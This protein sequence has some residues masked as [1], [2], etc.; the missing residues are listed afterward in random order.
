[1]SQ[2]N[3]KITRDAV[4]EITGGRNTDVMR[5]LNEWRAEQAKQEKSAIVV[6]T[7]TKIAQQSEESVAT[8]E[9]SAS[10]ASPSAP[11][12]YTTAPQ[13]DL[14]L[15]GR[16]SAERAAAMLL[17][18]N[19]LTDF[20]LENPDKLPEDLR[21]QV[22]A[23]Q[24]KFNQKSKQRQEAYDPETFTRMAIAQFQ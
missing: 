19:V 13:D 22:E 10:S 11:G 24:A 17:G 1:M 16:R 20:F 14:A 9:N 15:V 12:V 23:V 8:I 7:S 6:A 3:K 5:Y 2:E 18:E 4:R 21:L